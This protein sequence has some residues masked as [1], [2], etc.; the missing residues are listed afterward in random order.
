MNTEAPE[1]LNVQTSRRRL[2]G[3]K[4]ESGTEDQPQNTRLGSVAA[5]QALIR[6]I[7]TSGKLGF[8]LGYAALNSV[9]SAQAMCAYWWWLSI[10]HFVRCHGARVSGFPI[11]I[12][13]R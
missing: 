13:L 9:G 10:W 3:F 4:V 7:S 12:A 5:R 1:S 6:T 2:N 8:K 11:W